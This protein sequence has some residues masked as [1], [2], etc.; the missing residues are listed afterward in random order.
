MT[1]TTLGGVIP[2]NLMPFTADLEI[3]EAAYRSHLR[4]LIGTRGV[5][6]VT[7]VAHASEVASL[8]DA[9]QQRALAIAVE[10]ANGAV[11]IVAGVYDTG[12][13]RAVQRAK[14]AAKEG[15]DALLIFP[16]AAWDM[17]HQ[18]RPDMAYSY[19]SDIAGATDLP[20]IVFV[21]PTTSGL[22]IPTANL[23]RI[24]AEVENVAAIKEWSNDI[25]TYERNFR[26]LKSLDK[27]ISVLSSF[28]KAL[29][30]SL[31]IGADG[32]LSGHGSM[33]ASLH[34]EL[35]EAVERGDLAAARD[36]ATRIYPIT[37]VIYEDPFVDGHN[38]M[39]EA[40]AILGR[41]DQAHVRPPLQRITEAERERIRSAVAG[42][43]HEVNA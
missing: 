20:V 43:S 31:C 24:C 25:V 3:D 35:F 8:S 16:S 15:A 21:Y 39:K 18:A 37:K 34:V 28:S 42:L 4:D 40:L 38:R 5:T 6:A 26:E 10:E 29:L 30:P 2:A 22:H 36:V 12:N 13:A 19:V 32:I 23:V 14:M 7:T 41:I 1:R 17:G 27:H 33:I 9:E 11:G